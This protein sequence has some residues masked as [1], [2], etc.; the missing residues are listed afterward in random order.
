MCSIDDLNISPLNKIQEKNVFVNF[1]F[2]NRSLNFQL[3]F[4]QK[5]REDMGSKC[6]NM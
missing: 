6:K 4:E 2:A 1:F 3:D 5:V